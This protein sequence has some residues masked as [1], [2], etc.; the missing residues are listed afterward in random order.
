MTHRKTAIFYLS[1][2]CFPERP[3]KPYCVSSFLAMPAQLPESSLYSS[4][5]AA[6]SCHV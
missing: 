4:A 1:L 5:M 2:H 3:L 6:S